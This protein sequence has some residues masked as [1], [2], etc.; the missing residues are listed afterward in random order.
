MTTVESSL[1]GQIAR[2]ERAA[3]DYAAAVAGVTEAALTKR[4]DESN[5][6]ALEIVCHVRDTEEV[7]LDRVQ[8][9]LAAD[10]PPL[11][12]SD[13]DRWARERQYRRSDVGEAVAAF[14][15][16][17]ADTVSVL[18]GLAAAQLERGGVHPAR[19]RMTVRDIV[20]IMAWHDDNHLDQLA[21]ALQG[22]A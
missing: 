6:C 1:E 22:R 4:P 2:M 12:A 21:R 7:F 15:A 19:G 13:P 14:R 8:L 17:R 16:R 5:W 18:R 11:F 9:V 20:G 3:D 10:E